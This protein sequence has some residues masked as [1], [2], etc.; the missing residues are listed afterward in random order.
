MIK[1]VRDVSLTGKRIIMRV[2]FNVP[3]KDGKVQDDT[4]IVAAL[5]T[6]KYILDQKPRSLVLMSHLGDP[7]KDA[8]KAKEKAEK[9]G[10]PFDLKAY[11]DGKHRMKPVAEYL[12]KLLGREVAFLPSCFG[13]KAAIDALPY[14]YVAML[15]NT[16]FHKEETA[17]EP[18]VQEVL[19]RELASYGEVYVDD[20]F[21]TAHRAH[22]STATIAKFMAV[23]VGG[24]LMEKEVANLEPMLHNPPKPMVAIIG[25]AKVSSKIAVLENLLK[26]TSAL[27]I[28]GGMA[29]TFLKAQGVPV[30]KSMVE[31]D[32]LDT[33]RQLLDHA[34]AQGVEIVLPVDH[35]AADRFAPDATPVAVDSRA[36]PDGLMGL[37]VGPKTLRLYA[38]VISTAK[39][40]LWNGPVGVFE[41]DA[42]AKGTEQ[43]AK[44]VA[45]AT[46]RGALTVVGGGD[47]VAAVNKF[48]LAAKM[49]HVS[50]GGGA[51][52]EYLEGKEL[53]GIACLEQK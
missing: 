24:F 15:E 26:N 44:L 22:A 28:G 39:S 31:D 32:F 17:K 33:A 52:L 37:D 42:F 41:F 48:G 53:P 50:T 23:R 8:A 14:G 46:G 45:D 19:A 10:K 12:S 7:D 25:G 35:I 20:A 36:V 5:P 43:V 21:G 27:M 16:R 18:A 9:E 49:S 2:D 51:S 4:R 11:L 29:Y 30:G 13:Q 40:V 1:T 34:K 47:S 38:K 6:I 3:M